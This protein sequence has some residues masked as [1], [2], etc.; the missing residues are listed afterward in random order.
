MKPLAKVL[1][2]RT[3]IPLAFALTIAVAAT[4][5]S[6]VSVTLPG[7]PGTALKS[8]EQ[9]PFQEF[10]DSAQGEY[11][12]GNIRYAFTAVTLQDIN[13][14]HYGAPGQAEFALAFRP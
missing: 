11:S 7:P 6:K 4:S 14:A 5:C 3:R 8:L 2:Q 12:A 13:L 9:F 10:L 1:L